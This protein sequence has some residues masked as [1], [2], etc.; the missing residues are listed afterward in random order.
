MFPALR[1]I[2][3]LFAQVFLAP[4]AAVLL[5]A[6]SSQLAVTPRSLLHAPCPLHPTSCIPSAVSFKAAISLFH[7]HILDGGSSHA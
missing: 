6:R 1:N 2:L 5:A 7:S 3:R 4:A